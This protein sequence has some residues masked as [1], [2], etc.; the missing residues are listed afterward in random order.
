MKSTVLGMLG[1]PFTISK[2]S[3]LYGEKS[4]EGYDFR[5]QF[6]EK[7]KLSKY[8]VAGTHEWTLNLSNPSYYSGKDHITIISS[9]RKSKG[10]PDSIR[11]INS[12]GKIKGMGYVQLPVIF[13]SLS[14]LF[15]VGE[16]GKTHVIAD[17][18]SAD[19]QK[20]FVKW[21]KQ[22]LSVTSLNNPVAAVELKDTKHVFAGICDDI[23]DV[24]TNSAGEGNVGRILIAVLSMRRLKNKYAKDYKGGILLIDELDATLFGFSQQSIIEFLLSVSKEYNIQI[25]FTTHSP[26]ILSY[27][28]KLQR[29]EITKLKPDVPRDRYKYNNEIIYLSEEFD[30]DGV[31]GITGENIHLARELNRILNAIN[32]QPYRFEQFLHIY[33]EDDKAAKLISSI[34]DYKSI[35]ISQYVSFIDVDLGWTNYYQLHRKSVPEFRQSLIVLDN[36]V[37]RM[38]SEKKKVDYFHDTENVIFTPVDVE[39][40]MFAFLREH[41]NFNEFQKKLREKGYYFDYNTCFSEWPEEKYDTDEVKKWFKNLETKTSSVNLLFQLWCERNSDKV[42]EF[43]TAFVEKYNNLAEAINLDSLPI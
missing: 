14:R 31:R 20:L 7:F 35:D 4:I 43:L 41:K 1:Q 12:E 40:G 22:I 38:S 11:F 39:Q 3:P 16:T 26:I 24:F 21:Y 2:D 37:T 33:C 6:K 25:V 5:S 27:M 29:E 28:N 18:L 8:D 32:L 42:D 10:H 23:H 15:P 30:D 13:L 19:E 34:F 36:D 17:A 9:P